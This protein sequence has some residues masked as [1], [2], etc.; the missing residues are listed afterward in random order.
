MLSE[1]E[2]LYRFKPL[3]RPDWFDILEWRRGLEDLEEVCLQ[4]NGTL[5]TSK[6]VSAVVNPEKGKKSK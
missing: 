2:V 4:T 5:L 6:A 1:V 3:G